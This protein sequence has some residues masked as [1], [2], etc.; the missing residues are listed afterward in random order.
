V[1]RFAPEVQRWA[2]GP[3][4]P[5]LTEGEA[6]VW[7]LRIGGT[8]ELSLLDPAERERAFRFHFE[9]DRA[10]F[11]ATRTALRRLLSRYLGVAPASLDF[12]V[13]PHGKP[14]VADARGMRLRFNV[15]HSGE[16]A[17][18]ALA[19]DR[20]V[21]VDVE[22]HRPGLSVEALAPTVC[23]ERELPEL[24]RLEPAS[25]RRAFFGLWVGKEAVL[26]ASGRGLTLSPRSV[27]LLPLPWRVPSSVALGEAVPQ[28]YQAHP[29]EV[30][31]E[32]SGAFACAGD[33]LELRLFDLQTA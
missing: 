28:R 20:E 13:G 18:I 23:S 12:E 5:S 14:S 22:W 7:R 26:K 31:P 32:A 15:S 17:L 33:P 3:S 24:R 21:G 1:K 19:L 25:Q 2:P 29:L 10:R 6:H 27:E 4:R 8:A 30:G 9:R 16:L 11:A